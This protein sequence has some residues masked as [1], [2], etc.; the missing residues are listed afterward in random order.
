MSLGRGRV[1]RR[2]IGVGSGRIGSRRCE[3][4]NLAKVEDVR[5]N[6]D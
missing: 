6:L 1:G 3:T 2:R 4:I 5:S